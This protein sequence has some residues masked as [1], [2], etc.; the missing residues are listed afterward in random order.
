M[1]IGSKSEGVIQMGNTDE[2]MKLTLINYLKS[3]GEWNDDEVE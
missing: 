2:N 3:D 1:D